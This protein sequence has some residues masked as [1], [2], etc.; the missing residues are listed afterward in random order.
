MY[1][2]ALIDDE[3]IIVEGLRRVVKWADYGCQVAGTANDA[4]TGADMIRTVNP[5]ILFTDIRMPG[6]DGLVMLA[7]LRSEYPNMQVTVMTG[8]RDFAYAQE[9]IRLGVARF[10]LKPT[11]M[12]EINEALQTMVSR[13]DKLPPEE[14]EEQSQSAGSFIVDQA[15]AYM[16]SHHREKLT[17][18]AVADCCYVSQ[19]HLSKLLNRYTG[20][21]FYDIL[22]AIRIQKA[23]ELLEDPSLKIGEIGERVGYANT[24]HFARTFKKLEGMSANEFRNSLHR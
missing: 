13:L 20:K 17:L 12:D 9:A 3:N 16:Q 1:R 7:G 15:C 11:K 19:W 21:S 14:A 4:A 5:H 23:K 2:V 18:Q 6:E 10:L 22:N 24:A 8:Y